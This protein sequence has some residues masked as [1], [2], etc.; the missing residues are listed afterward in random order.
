MGR[1]RAPP[2]RRFQR[3][4]DP[5]LA[6]LCPVLINVSSSTARLINAEFYDQQNQRHLEFMTDGEQLQ[7]LRLETV[8]R[9]LLQN[10]G[11]SS[12][13]LNESY[14]S[15]ET[16]VPFGDSTPV[17][18]PGPSVPNA[19]RTRAAARSESDIS[20]LDIGPSL[21][22]AHNSS[23]STSQS[24]SLTNGHAGTRRIRDTDPDFVPESDSEASDRPSEP[25]V[26]ADD[27]ESVAITSASGS[28]RNEFPLTVRQRRQNQPNIALPGSHVLPSSAENRE[29]PATEAHGLENSNGAEPSA[30]STDYFAD[31]ACRRVYSLSVPQSPRSPS[32]MSQPP[33]HR[34]QSSFGGMDP[35]FSAMRNAE[36]A[37]RN[38]RDGGDPQRANQ[39]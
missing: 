2:R 22:S 11:R 12:T 27:L 13:P 32:E 21:R 31:E 35:V 36:R 37:S 8:R 39:N 26:R 10:M 5:E 1:T 30:S 3:H 18:N 16:V 7:L 29:S 14:S 33:L 15:H 17:R 19:V 34:S 6:A 9:I 28:V 38:A 4:L 24:S 25:C 20:V 23:G